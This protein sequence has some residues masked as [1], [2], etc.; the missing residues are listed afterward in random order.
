L[1]GMVDNPFNNK[2]AGTAARV[3]MGSTTNPC[4]PSIMR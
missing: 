3:S 2:Y 1:K 4:R